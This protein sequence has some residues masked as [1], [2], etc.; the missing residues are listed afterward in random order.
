MRRLVFLVLLLLFPLECLAQEQADSFTWDFGKIKEGAVVK[1][2]FTIKNETAK[3]IKIKDINTSCG[4]TVSQVK[5]R[6]LLPGESAE[7]EV[8][9]DSKGYYGQVQQYVYVHTD[10]LDNPIIRFIIKAYPVK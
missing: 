8:R 1:H 3:P 10:N 4:C 7:V 9:F 2:V 5:K 6:D